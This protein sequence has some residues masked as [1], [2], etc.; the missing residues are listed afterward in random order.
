[1]SVRLARCYLYNSV[2]YNPAYTA[3]T[4][5]RSSIGNT[6]TPDYTPRAMSTTAEVFAAMGEAVAGDGGKA[7]QKKFKVR[8]QWTNHP[9]R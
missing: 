5:V 1:M 2:T 6:V 3:Y 8:D 9:T 7:L 4:V